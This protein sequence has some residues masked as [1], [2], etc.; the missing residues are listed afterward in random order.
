MEHSLDQLS[1]LPDEI[2]LIIFKKLKNIDVLYT[3]MGINTRLDKIVHDP[4]FTS[5]LTLLRC[6]SNYVICPLADTMLDRFCLQILPQIR[7]KIK[8]LNIESSSIER[9]LRAAEYSNLCRLGLYNMTED[10]AIRLFIGKK[11][12]LN[13]FYLYNLMSTYDYTFFITFFHA[14]FVIVTYGYIS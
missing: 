4:I 9:I 3:L 12:N 1:N 7:L 2:L 14:K 8:H 11:I 10:T 5:S 13:Y 6:S